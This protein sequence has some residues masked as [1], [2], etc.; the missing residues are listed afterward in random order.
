MGRRDAGRSGALHWKLSFVNRKSLDGESTIVPVIPWSESTQA[1]ELS[2][3]LDNILQHWIAARARCLQHGFIE[4]NQF[5]ISVP[6]GN[7]RIL[8]PYP[9]AAAT[10][11]VCGEE[12]GFA[13]YVGSPGPEFN[14]LDTGHPGF[15]VLRVSCFAFAW[16]LDIQKLRRL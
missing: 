6:F 10:A 1:N 8:F 2:R 5:N 11:A 12:Q 15:D 16:H 9:L 7:E 3:T 4:Y 14:R 13:L